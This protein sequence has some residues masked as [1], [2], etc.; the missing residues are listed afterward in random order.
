[1]QQKLISTYSKNS[2][3]Q[4]S[5]AEL[6][7]IYFLNENCLPDT[8]F[9]TLS[10]INFV[11]DKL[12]VNQADLVFGLKKYNRNVNWFIDEAGQL[13]QTLTSGD[14]SFYE[15]DENGDLLYNLYID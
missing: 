10:D 1:M 4:N 7:H 9:A 2:Y 3:F 15:I 12:K 5:T 14:G 8:F 6:Q 11:L 13:F